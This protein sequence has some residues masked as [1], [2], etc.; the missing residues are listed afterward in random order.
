MKIKFVL[1][2]VGLFLIPAVFPAHA[3]TILDSTGKTVAVPDQISRIICSGPGALRLITYFN[4]QDL[5]VAVDD[6][7]TA[8]KQFDARPYAIANP[9]YKKLPVFGE[10]RG[11]DDP[12][13]ILGLAA[14][15]QVIF[16][17]YAG[18]G[19]DPVE[20][21]QKT[22]IP[23]VVLGYGN[24]A[25]Q[26]DIIYNSLRIIG[27]VLNRE[28]RA[29]ALI[30]F[31][32]E[33]IA[34]LN[35]RTASVENK[36]TC[37]IGGIAHKGPHGFPSTEPN[38]PP[39]E[40]VNAANIANASDVKVK[41]LSHSSFSKEKLLEANPEVL[42]LDLSTL[43]MGDGHSGLDELKTDPVFQA[44]DAVADG[45]VYGVLPYNW[46]SQNFGSILADAWYVGK[47]LY[48]EQFE[49]VDP[50][51]KA[52]EIYEFLLSAKVYAAMD[53]LF[54]NKAFKPVDLGAK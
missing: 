38:Y 2:C 3:K 27:Q 39:F 36:K 35:R 17:T 4:A 31:F 11:N 53:A 48:P 33:Q 6:M 18:M 8:R 21:S 50:V 24:L 16:K 13:K 15:P 44:L 1:L 29:E 37:F 46:Y 45:R 42:F 30:G 34:E 47:V 10:F 26:R 23:V 14:Q 22:D 9:Q 7:E 41:N 12:E 28:E 52:D 40:F 25:V 20:L 19:Y 5:V 54:R 51:K 43:Q 32:D 49:D